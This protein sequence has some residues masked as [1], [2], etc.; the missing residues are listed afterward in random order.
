MLLTP[1]RYKFNQSQK[2]LHKPT[3]DSFKP[4]MF[5]LSQKVHV[6]RH[7]RRQFAF[8]DLLPPADATRQMAP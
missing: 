8:L 7:D 3:L 6:H 4:A 2:L 5:A 1:E